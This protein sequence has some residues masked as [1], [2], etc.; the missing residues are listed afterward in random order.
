MPEPEVKV[1]Y[2]VPLLVLQPHQVAGSNVA[3]PR[4]D[5]AE[6]DRAFDDDAGLPDDD[7]GPDEALPD[8]ERG[9]VV[10]VD[11]VEGVPAVEV[12]ESCDEGGI[13]E[14]AKEFDAG[15]EAPVSG[16]KEIPVTV[17]EVG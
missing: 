5:P 13:V 11:K 9:V 2:K 10:I 7:E 3:R 15:A 17:T 12:V 8:G 1:G 6:Q 4:L 16:G 14:D